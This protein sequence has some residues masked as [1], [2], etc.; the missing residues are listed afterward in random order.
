MKILAH[1]ENKSPFYYILTGFFLILV[2]GILDLLTGYEISISLFYLLPISLVTWFAKKR[3]GVAASILSAIV[4]LAAEIANQ[5]NYSH[6]AVYF[7][8][9][10][11]RFGFFITVTL[12]LSALKNALEHEKNLS[13]TD[14]MTGATSASFFYDLLQLEMDRFQRYQHPFTVA[15]L[16]LDNFKSVNDQFG[17]NTGDIVLRTVVSHAQKELR[18][19]DI[20]ARLGGDEFVILFPETDPETARIVI[21]KILQGL[22]LEMIKG[23]WP[24]TFSIGAI[25]FYAIPDTTNH[26]IKMVDDLMYKVKSTGKNAVNYSVYRG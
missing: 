9:T 22:L 8:N 24:V 10:I 15:Y 7:W 13:R 26:L 18:K 16:D 19:T 23:D 12:L 17:H 3:I 11:I 5:P 2:V 14:Q 4:W 25:T 6:P 1:F 20:V 21:S